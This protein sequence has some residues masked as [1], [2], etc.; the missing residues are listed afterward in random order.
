MAILVGQSQVK[1]VYL[2][3]S[4]VFV[5][6]RTLSFSLGTGVAS[7]TYSGKTI[8]GKSISGTVTTSTSISIDYGATLTISAIAKTGYI[9]NSYTTGVVMTNDQLVTITANSSSFFTNINVCYNGTEYGH[10]Y[11][12]KIGTFQYSRNGSSWSGSMSNEDWTQSFEVGSYLYLRNITAA[13]GFTLASVTYNG[14]VINQ[15]SG[16]YAVQIEGGEYTVAINFVAATAISSIG[17]ANTSSISTNSL[18]RNAWT[19]TCNVDVAVAACGAGTVIGTI[20]EQ[21]RPSTTKT[22]TVTWQTTDTNGSVS[23]STAT[24][25]INTD[26]TI[27]SNLESIGAGSSSVGGKWGSYYSTWTTNMAFNMTWS[28]I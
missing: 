14:K 13:P 7:A 5:D 23:S 6:K 3:T 12:N 11:G 26:G 2:D 4:L 24:I 10:L 28:V 20:P 17:F 9:L 1:L 21:Y 18:T 15:S 8:D 22:T 19:V 27:V 16:Q 25:T